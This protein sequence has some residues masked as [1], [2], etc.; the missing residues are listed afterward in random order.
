MKIPTWAPLRARPVVAGLDELPGFV[1]VTRRVA[2]RIRG[3][4][5]EAE[6]AASVHRLEWRHGGYRWFARLSDAARL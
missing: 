3:R 1:V 6:L 5:P 2:M 4:F